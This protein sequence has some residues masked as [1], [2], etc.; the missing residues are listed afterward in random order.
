MSN[1]FA[2]EQSVSVVGDGMRSASPNF[3]ASKSMQKYL[4]IKSSCVHTIFAPSDAAEE[5]ISACFF[6]LSAGFS[7]AANC[8]NAIFIN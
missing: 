4:L 7:D 5:I 3:P 2:K 8:V 1:F 6:K